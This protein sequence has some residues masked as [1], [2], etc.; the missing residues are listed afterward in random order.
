MGTR[1]RGVISC[2]GNAWRIPT[3]TLICTTMIST[4]T[5]ILMIILGT[6]TGG[7]TEDIGALE[8]EGEAVGDKELQRKRRCHLKV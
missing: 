2:N 4:M 7:M 5:M 8:V 6:T 3:S 1:S